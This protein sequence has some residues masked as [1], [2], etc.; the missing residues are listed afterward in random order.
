MQGVDKQHRAHEWAE[1]D[2]CVHAQLMHL[3]YA[4]MCFGGNT[5]VVSLEIV[6]A[7]YKVL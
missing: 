2:A 3:A 1:P 7:D 4:T 5:S 6:C